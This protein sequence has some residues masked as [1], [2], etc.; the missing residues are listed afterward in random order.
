MA[1]E[2]TAQNGRLVK[3]MGGTAVGGPGG[4]WCACLCRHRK[5]CAQR[6]LRNGH[7]AQ[8]VIPLRVPN[9]VLLFLPPSRAPSLC[10]IL[11]NKML[12]LILIDVSISLLG[13][14]FVQ[15]CP[16]QDDLTAAGGPAYCFEVK[17]SHSPFQD[18]RDFTWWASSEEG[19]KDWVTRIKKS[20]L[21]SNIDNG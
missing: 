19:R 9:I 13:S 20:A 3:A 11:T 15:A 16:E 5:C 17:T 14:C 12:V 18:Q 6:Q 1:A 10:A 8:T 4:L 2:E 21:H 7:L